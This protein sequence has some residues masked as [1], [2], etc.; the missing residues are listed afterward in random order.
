[1]F[2]MMKKVVAMLVVLCVL[3][4]FTLVWLWYGVFVGRANLPKPSNITSFTECVAAG[5]TI[6]KSSPETCRTPDGIVFTNAVSEPENNV[7]SP[8][9]C[10]PIFVLSVS[11]GDVV[12]SPLTV[13][14]TAKGS[15][16]FE[17]SMPVSILDGQG[18]VVTTSIAT[19]DGEWMTESCVPFTANFVFDVPGTQTGTLRFQ[20]DNPSGETA[21]D[22][23]FDLP[24]QFWQ[25]AL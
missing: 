10:D 6:V 23:Y 5:N 25:K 9:S 13:S 16:F 22:N 14:G 7:I 17:A 8:E 15:W 1:M 20:K 12:A 19:A 21:K 24:V 3:S 4:I 2:I 18:N 11:P